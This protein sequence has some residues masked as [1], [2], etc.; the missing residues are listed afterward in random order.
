MVFVWDLIQQ[1]PAS[2]HPL[3]GAG[4]LVRR[5]AAATGTVTTEA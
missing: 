2:Q 3:Q 1:L 4:A 5:P